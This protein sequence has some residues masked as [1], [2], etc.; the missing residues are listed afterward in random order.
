MREFICTDSRWQG[1][2]F[3]TS[4]D[5]AVAAVLERFDLDAALVELSILGCDDGEITT[6]NRDFRNKPTPTNVLSW[7]AEE[8]ASAQRGGTPLRPQPGPDGLI[9]LGDIAIS[10]DTCAA[11]ATAAGIPLQAHVSHL[12]VHGLLHLLGYDHTCDLDADLMEGIEVEI[13]GKLCYDNPYR[14]PAATKATLTRR[15][16]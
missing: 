16:D 8:R 15:Q 9:E 14:D 2:G 5:Q 13:L 7:P 11:E 6:L 1:P 12:I 3:E 10:Y 4:I